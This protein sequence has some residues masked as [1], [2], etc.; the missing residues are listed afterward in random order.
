MLMLVSADLV[1][2]IRYFLSGKRIRKWSIKEKGR[3][4][5]EM[6]IAREIQ[7]NLLK[8]LSEIRDQL[9]KICG[10]DETQPISTINYWIEEIDVVL[11]G[12]ARGEARGLTGPLGRIGE[13][14][15]SLVRCQDEDST[16]VIQFIGNEGAL[17]IANSG[18][19]ILEFDGNL[20][21]NP[22]TKPVGESPQ[23]Q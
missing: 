22:Y 2:R 23:L 17:T 14:M 3:G 13:I 16:K 1:L 7:G 15:G 6:V 20:A 19:S 9:F 8:T 5:R 10:D 21:I 12:E 11:V 18:D 4:G